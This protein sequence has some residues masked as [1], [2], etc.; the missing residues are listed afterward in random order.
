M[1]NLEGN[2]QNMYIR[3]LGHV[4]HGHQHRERDSFVFSTGLATV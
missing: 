2:I 4:G 3:L 1:Y